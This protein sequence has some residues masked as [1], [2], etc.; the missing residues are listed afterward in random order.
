[1]TR[2]QA[3]EKTAAA[4]GAP[5]MSPQQQQLVGTLKAL[6]EQ[7]IAGEMVGFIGVAVSK[8]IVGASVI[9]GHVTPQSVTLQLRML[10]QQVVAAAIAAAQ[11]ARAS[12]IV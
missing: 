5:E 12:S 3:A 2:N 8:N 9:S 1:M 10:E 11:N 7:A 4:E 6:T